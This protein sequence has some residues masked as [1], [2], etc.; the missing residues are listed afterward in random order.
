M[1]TLQTPAETLLLPVWGTVLL[2]IV[3]I[4]LGL[5]VGYV[6]FN[7]L[8]KGSRPAAQALALGLI[9]L[10]AV[11]AVFGLSISFNQAELIRQRSPVV[12]AVVQTIGLTLIIYAIY[13]PL[14]SGSGEVN[15][16]E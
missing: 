13:T 6:A 1:T 2:I 8:R 3:T 5:V 15:T 16:D 9:F 4:P 7:G 10:T 12:R 11:N 14:E